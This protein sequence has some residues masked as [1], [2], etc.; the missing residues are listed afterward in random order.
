VVIPGA[1]VDGTDWEVSNFDDIGYASDIDL[2]QATAESVNTVYAQLVVDE[3]VGAER[4]AVMAKDLGI[5]SQIDAYPALALGTEEVSP[6]EMADAYLT[7]A[8]EGS[9]VEPFLISKVTDATGQVL[10]EQKSTQVRV[11]SSDEAAI[12]NQT[13]RQVVEAGSGV[14]AKLDDGRQVA[15]KTG[16]TQNARDAWFVGYTP[17]NCCVVAVWMGYAKSNKPMVELRGRRVTGGAF[18]ADLFSRFMNRFVA[19]VDTGEFELPSEDALGEVIVPKRTKAPVKKK[20]PIVV[21]ADDNVVEDT[22]APQ[23]DG[24]GLGEPATETPTPSPE[25]VPVPAEETPTPRPSV[26]PPVQ[27]DAPPPIIE[28]PPV[29]VE[30]PVQTPVEGAPV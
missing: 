7:F 27:V 25:P 2:T 17:K 3:R 30:P 14:K 23:E 19:N 11:L 16:T 6:L 15:G 13:L 21:E 4:V 29:P 18:P 5:R 28:T 1:N 12:M 24:D 9:R 8:R 22:V 10:F 26:P 20:K